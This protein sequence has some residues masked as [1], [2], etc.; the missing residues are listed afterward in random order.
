MAK[1]SWSLG[2]LIA[3]TAACGGGTTPKPA[4][5]A[6]A[7]PVI[8]P[9]APVIATPA[10]PALPPIPSTPAAAPA[11][12]IATAASPAPAALLPAIASQVDRAV[13]GMG[14]AVSLEALTAAVG[15]LGVDLRG[16]DLTRP[17]RGLLLDPSRFSQPVVLV[18]GVGDEAA[19]A[20]AAEQHGARYQI[21]AGYAA[22]GAGPALTAAGGY[23]LTTL[24]ATPVPPGP[25]VDV[26]VGYL[27][28]HYGDLIDQIVGQAGDAD[29]T[30]EQRAGRELV[31]GGAAALL[32]QLDHVQL[33]GELVGDHTGAQLRLVPR[34]GTT[35]ATFVAQ[36]V[37]ATFAQLERVPG[38]AMAFGGRV[39]LGELYGAMAAAIEPMMARFYGTGSGPLLASWRRWTAIGLGEV[40]AGVELRDGL[41][42]MTMLMD[43]ADP[44]GLTALWAEA[45]AAQVKARG[46]VVAVKAKTTT[47]RGSKLSVLT[48]SFTAAATAADRAGAAPF[49]G[50][51]GSVF[52]VVGKTA[53]FAMGKNALPDARA[54]VDRVTAGAKATAPVSAGLRAAIAEARRRRESLL[55]AFDIPALTALST[56]A[57]RPGASPPTSPAAAGEPF[58]LAL[59]VDAGTLVVRMTLPVDQVKAVS[60]MQAAQ[61]QAATREVDATIAVM[62]GMADQVCAC[63]DL[64]CAQG[65]MEAMARID[66]PSVKP[67]ADQMNRAMAIATRMAECQ[68]KLM[69]SSPTP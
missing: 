52:G 32:R 40:G 11:E 42:S 7:A 59:G 39:E 5:P 10:E 12:L 46:G 23:A 26:D 44:K 34:P 33:A 61:S 37:P 1:P 20:A 15:E 56:A 62:S 31:T 51:M 50:A 58:V 63:R 54:L 53:V 27:T 49:G 69:A 3:V 29:E 60:A 28:L 35:L 8:E 41:I 6:P 47:Y 16:V 45:V 67:T 48:S 55:L 65:V 13:P 18:V 38:G 36:Q 17:V 66:E 25:T 21:H 9:V 30:A 4:A 22:I 2:V 14:A 19:L 43:V 64:A 68:R 57:A 24:L